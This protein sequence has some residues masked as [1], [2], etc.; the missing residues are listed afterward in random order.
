MLV[1]LKDIYK[2]IVREKLGSILKVVSILREKINKKEPKTKICQKA[3]LDLLIFSSADKQTKS[4]KLYKII[5][6][7]FKV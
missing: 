5:Y 3:P 2:S 6:V 4:Y 7:Y 1:I